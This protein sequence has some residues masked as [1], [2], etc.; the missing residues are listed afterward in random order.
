MQ[1]NCALI[2]QSILA[3]S[4]ALA[5]FTSQTA[6]ATLIN[7]TN[8]GK[9]L[10]YSTVS[11]V[12]WTKDA[13]LLGALFASQGFNTVV[14]AIIAASPTISNLPNPISP[15]GIYT[16]S[17]SDFN[18]SGGVT[19]FGAMG[20]VNYLNSINYGGSS[21]WRLPSWSNTTYEIT[22][23]SPPM[24]SPKAMNWLRCISTI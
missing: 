10:V 2:K 22:T 19:W 15:T 14:N 18:S 11:D 16:L 20:Y 12:T 4:L 13:N 1:F 17:A 9:E 21:Q 24:V 6:Q 5:S 7:Y 3:A 23:T 8:D